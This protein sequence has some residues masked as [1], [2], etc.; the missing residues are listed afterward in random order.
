MVIEYIEYNPEKLKEANKPEPN[1]CSSCDK[2]M[3][4]NFTE[5]E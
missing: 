1:P 4:T 2:T 5:E 3:P